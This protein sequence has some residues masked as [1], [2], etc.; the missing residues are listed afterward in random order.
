MGLSSNR[1]CL[2]VSWFWD[3]Y[4]HPTS[5]SFQAPQSTL[6]PFPKHL[7]RTIGLVSTILDSLAHLSQCPPRQQIKFISRSKPL[8]FFVVL[9]TS[10]SIPRHHKS[11]NKSQDPKL[12]SESIIKEFKNYC[13]C[14]Y[15]ADSHY[16]IDQKMLISGL[17][18]I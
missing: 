17:M 3:Q 18:G 6:S 13:I 9:G 15:L 7:P 16:D 11:W 5:V 12:L 8:P 14:L 4:L 1:L 2:P 10:G